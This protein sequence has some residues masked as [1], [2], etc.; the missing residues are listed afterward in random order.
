MNVQEIFS[1]M[2]LDLRIEEIGIE[3]IGVIVR[4]A[5]EI[6]PATY[7]DIL[8]SDQISY[9]MELFYS[10]DS[11]RTQIKEKQ[12]QFIIA[13]MGEEPVAFASYAATEDAVIYKLHK[14]YV[15][16][17]VQGKGVGKFMIRYII[18]AL[19]AHKAIALELNVNRNNPAKNFYEKLGFNV[20]REED[21]DIGKGYYMNDFVMQKSI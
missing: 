16:P 6:W 2:D 1:E 13:S 12:H 21:I 9:M 18:Q 14:I 7:K 8:P 4:L 10:P 20:I 5:N 15:H 11:L 3:E 17:A 19:H